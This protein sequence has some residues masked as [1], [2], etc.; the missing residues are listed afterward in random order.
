MIT[1]H[2]AHVNVT[3]E[4][5]DVH[6][7]PL[8]T[9]LRGTPKAH[10]AVEDM[11][12]VK[13]QSPTSAALGHLSVE[14]SDDSRAPFSIAFAPGQE[15]SAQL[16]REAIEAALQ[17]E[18][19]PGLGANV[20]IPG[21]N[22]VA[23]DVETANSDWGSICQIGAVKV[24]DGVVSEN[25]YVTLCKPPTPVDNF[26]K[27]N[28]AIHGIQ[29][30]DVAEAPQF[31]ETVQE[32]ASFVGGLPLVAHNAQFDTTALTRAAEYSDAQL[33]PSYFGCSLALARSLNLQVKNHKLPT[34]AKE[35]GYDLEQHHDA[36]ADA[37]A[38]A[39]I[40]LGAARRDR[41]SGSF[42]E[43]FFDHYLTLGTMANKKVFPVLKDRSGA[44]VATQRTTIAE[45][46]TPPQDETAPGA[47]IQEALLSYSEVK[48]GP[49][50]GTDATSARGK[51][52]SSKST[53]GRAPWQAVATPDTVP[54]ANQEADPSSLL[55]GQNVTLTGDF[56]PWD[57]GQ[58]WNLIAQAGGHVGKNVTKKTT[59]LVAGAWH[60]VTSKEKKAREYQQKGQDIAIWSA[61][62][63]YNALGVDASPQEEQPPF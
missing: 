11:S 14:F 62:D 4:A 26:D 33:P 3:A 53:G 30:E 57:K 22:F 28:I 8:L 46:P 15:S 2:G 61:D 44:G 16:C 50:S 9:A 5:I 21:L 42:A 51:A 19:I 34:V 60:S 25:S 6:Y 23:V 20:A 7:G 43:L 32:L 36:L 48:D 37:R 55:Y 41:F 17:G 12:A 52:G 39:E 13:L 49:R 40:V 29:A 27:A 31:A 54:E 18:D 45:H 63:L 1:A 35:F 58:L 38:C 10:I 59:I 24:L 56:E 47:E